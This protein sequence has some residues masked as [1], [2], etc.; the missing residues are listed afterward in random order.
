MKD[1][2][3]STS[4]GYSS[5]GGGRLRAFAAGSLMVIGYTYVVLLIV[6]AGLLWWGG[7]RWWLSTVLLFGPRWILGLPLLVLFPGALWLAPRVGVALAVGLLVF[8]FPFL[9][10]NVGIPRTSGPG[11]LEIVTINVADGRNL[12]ES[13]PEFVAGSGADIVALQECPRAVR[14]SNPTIDGYEF[15]A[16]RG[17]CLFSRL[18]IR[19][20][21]TDID[22]DSVPGTVAR[23]TLE[24]PSG[25][26]ISFTNLHLPT[27]RAGL[28]DIREGDLRTGIEHLDRDIRL[29][30]RAAETARALVDGAQAPRIVVG[31]FNA[32]PESRIQRDAWGDLGNAFTIAGA[33]FG[34]TRYNGWIRARIDHV[35]FD[36]QWTAVSARVGEDVGSDHRPV[37]VRLRPKD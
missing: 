28:E 11:D 10:M 2:V 9:G 15:H 19:D 20:V 5:S 6:A 26:Q 3:L 34:F 18:A 31:D 21:A 30:T 12:L 13:I 1:D 23:Y 17:L 16:H 14:G 29:R 25:D 32:P 35:L 27:P 8:L 33:G 36:P 37:V 4:K 24:H 7:D 22:H